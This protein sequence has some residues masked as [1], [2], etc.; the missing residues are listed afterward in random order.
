MPAPDDATLD[1]LIDLERRALNRWGKG[2]TAGYTDLYADDVT[3]FDPLVEA[4]IDGLAAMRAYYEP[5]NGRISVPRYEILNPAV[6][7]SGDLALLSYNLVNYQ[8]AA[9]GHESTGSRWNCTEVYR[10]D[11]SQWKIVHSHWSFTRHAAF[12]NLTP[13][14][15]EAG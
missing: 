2:D 10:R 6:V 9:D 4:R 5:W 7:S 14:Q 12:Q 11:G 8:R 3:Y 15:S 13:E 1:L